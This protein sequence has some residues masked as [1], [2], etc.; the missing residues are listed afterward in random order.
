MSSFSGLGAFRRRHAVLFVLIGAAVDR[1]P[2]EAWQYHGK[3]RLER[4]QASSQD[5]DDEFDKRPNLDRPDQYERSKNVTRI[6]VK[7]WSCTYSGVNIVP[8]RIFGVCS[9]S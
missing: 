8:G 9:C 5:A 2:E 1:R 3:E 6:Y 4:W 7:I